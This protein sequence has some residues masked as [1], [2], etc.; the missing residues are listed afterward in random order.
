MVKR[1]I[2]RLNP[3]C[4]TKSSKIRIATTVR[5]FTY[6]NDIIAQQNLVKEGLRPLMV[7]FSSPINNI[8]QQNLV[9]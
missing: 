1:C 8:A 2:R 7:S 4:T 3:Y 6:S 9:K 5:I